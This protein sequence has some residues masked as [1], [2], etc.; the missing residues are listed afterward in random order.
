M[1]T[2]KIISPE[3]ASVTAELIDITGKVVLR[4][5]AI[6]NSAGISVLTLN[7]KKIKEGIYVLKLICGINVQTT[8]VV[9]KN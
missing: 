1:L 2:G 4:N 7:T 9:K 6:T 8:I 5:T 3:P